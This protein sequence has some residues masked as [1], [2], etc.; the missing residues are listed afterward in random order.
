M[1]ESLIYPLFEY[2]VLVGIAVISIIITVITTITTKYVTDQDG[3]RKIKKDIK[4]LNKELRS[5]SDD[6]Q[7]VQEIQKKLWPKQRD[8][9]K[10]SFTPMIYYG[11][12]LFIVFI[13]L[14]AT[15]GQAP[16]APGEEFTITAKHTEDLD[17]EL[18]SDVLDV[19]R[20]DMYSTDQ[21]ETQWLATGQEVGT[22]EFTVSLINSSSSVSH[23]V[24]ITDSFGYS[25]PTQ[26]YQDSKI[27]EVTVGYD[28]ITPFGD[29][30]IFGWQ[31][32]WLAT[33]ILFG[34]G[35]NLIFRK[36][37]NLA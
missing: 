32:G 28:K 1:L 36:I 12:P 27:E 34:V 5:V 3:I 7:K 13:W 6:Q 23:E 31:P 9:L 25:T 26:T 21:S 29:F 14:G 4:N 20:N 24:K 22:H 19:E 2:S 30:D 33:Y 18:T 8:L 16:I 10:Q 17:L 35:S 15:L 11:V 37:M